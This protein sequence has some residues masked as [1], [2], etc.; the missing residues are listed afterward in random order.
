MQRSSPPGGSTDRLVDWSQFHFD[1]QQSGFN[2]YEDTLGPT[3]VQDLI[4]LWRGLDQGLQLI[5]L[6]DRLGRRRVRGHLQ[7]LPPPRLPRAMPSGPT[8]AVP[9]T[10]DTDPPGAAPPPPRRGRAN[11]YLGTNTY[12]LQA[13]DAADGHPVWSAHIGSQMVGAPVVDRGVV[14]MA[15]S[16]GTVR[17]FDAN[18]GEE[19]GKRV[20]GPRGSSEDNTL[21]IADG[22][23]F[24]TSDATYALVRAHGAEIW[25]NPIAAYGGTPAVVDG[26]VSP[27][28]ELDGIG[29][30]TGPTLWSSPCGSPSRRRP[31]RT[32]GVYVNGLDGTTNVDQRRRWVEGAMDRE[33]SALRRSARHQPLRSP[34]A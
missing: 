22:T 4:P 21:A 27:G 2:R 29:R 5:L 15:P 31:G 33:R 1:A 16:D 19:L 12:D 34:T 6:A 13:F 14:Y 17:A 7:P 11:V 20:P 24:V 23:I 9:S 8:R 10:L 3:N 25:R 32:R 26:V 18:T 28:G 30:Q